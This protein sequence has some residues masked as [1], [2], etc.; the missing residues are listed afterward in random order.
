MSVPA[1][2]LSA[3]Q[4]RQTADIRLVRRFLHRIN[5]NVV[6]GTETLFADFLRCGAGVDRN[7]HDVLVLDRP[8]PFYRDA[9]AN[10][11]GRMLSRKYMGPLK[12]PRRPRGLREAH[13]RR[14]VRKRPPDL[15]LSWDCFASDELVRIADRYQ[16]PLIYQEQGSAWSKKTNGPTVSSFLAA[17]SGA[18]CN[19]DAAKR[20]LQL[21]WGYR[22]PVRV[23]PNGL[24]LAVTDAPAPMRRY[25]SDRPIRIGMMSRQ[26]PVKGVN[27]GLHAARL[28]RD[29]GN[30]LELHIAGT[31]TDEHRHRRLA[32]RLGIST[33]V[34]WHGLVRDVVGFYDAIDLLLVP[35]LSEPFGLVSIEAAARGCPVV[36]AGVDGLA[37]TVDHGRSGYRLWPECPIEDFPEVDGDPSRVPA[38]GY[39]PLGDRLQPP[40]FVSPESLADTVREVFQDPE[41]Y[42][43][44]SSYGKTW[45]RTRF[46]MQDYAK[47][48]RDNMESLAFS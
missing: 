1:G 39:D 3:L 5:W 42:E 36:V 12:L 15:L 33:S 48:L 23:N 41:R 32:A 9:L 21:R 10:G 37:E 26:I 28:L 47:R 34:F 13:V 38:M 2:N 20:M 22:G 43:A 29:E 17:M 45:S 19:S 18:I 25:P 6:G 11:T 8:H 31:G 44:M 40:R 24:R 46:S 4:H 27:L 30:D 7:I 14:A 16:C 35:S